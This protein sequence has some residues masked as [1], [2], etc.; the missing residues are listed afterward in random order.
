VVDTEMMLKVKKLVSGKYEFM[1]LC[2]VAVNDECIM[3]LLNVD[4]DW[5]H[6]MLLQSYFCTFHHV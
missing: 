2:E 5:R 1:Y 6:H 3:L 4:S